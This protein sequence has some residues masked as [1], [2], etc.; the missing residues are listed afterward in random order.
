[1]N[2]M[3]FFRTESA[4]KPALLY[5]PM[6]VD[7]HSRRSGMGDLDGLFSNIVKSIAKPFQKIFPA[8]TVLGKILDPLGLTDPSRNLNLVGRVADV[9]GTA[10]AVVGAGWAIGAATAG[11]G[12]G[13]WATTATGAKVAAAAAGKAAAGIGKGIGAV[14][15][16]VA[17]ALLT[18]SFGGSNPA[19]ETGQVQLPQYGIDPYSVSTGD[20]GYLSYTGGGGGGPLYTGLPDS[21]GSATVEVT[22]EMP[23]G[24]NWLLIGGAAAVIFMV[25]YS[26]R[27]KGKSHVR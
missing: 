27:K 23:K 10:A 3:R 18:G 21:Q 22:G 12:G 26:S 7:H 8:K 15:K 17:P 6:L 14:A 4:T 13:F 1:M 25:M 9:A 2:H 11:T 24:P 5:T 16:A 20:Q 19:V